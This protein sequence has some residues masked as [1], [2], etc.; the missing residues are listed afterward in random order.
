MIGRL[1]RH[2]TGCMHSEIRGHSEGR[3]CVQMAGF[4]GVYGEANS[5]MVVKMPDCFCKLL[6]QPFR[7]NLSKLIP[8]L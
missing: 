3:T 5:V 4:H 7:L 1:S 8:W 2:C 6:K